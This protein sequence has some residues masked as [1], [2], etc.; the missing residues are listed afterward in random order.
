MGM[1]SIQAF[2]RPGERI[3]VHYGQLQPVPEP[4]A[5]DKSECMICMPANKKRMD[6]GV[7]K[8]SRWLG[9]TDS[10]VYSS[11]YYPLVLSSC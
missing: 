4:G 3:Q 6:A 11:N 10:F 1:H 2:Y 9:S 5:I 7:G 8:G